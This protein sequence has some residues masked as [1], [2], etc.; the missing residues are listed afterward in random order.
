MSLLL[1]AVSAA[2]G[3]VGGEE[4]AA[5]AGAVQGVPIKAPT[6]PVSALG[7][8]PAASHATKP[9][10]SADAEGKTAASALAAEIIKEAQAGSVAADALIAG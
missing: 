10:T 9:S 2:A 6:A 7:E 1:V 3:P 4:T 5:G 8:T